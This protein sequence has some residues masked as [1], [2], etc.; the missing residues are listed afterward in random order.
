M[1]LQAELD[2]FNEEGTRNLEPGDEWKKSLKSDVRPPKPLVARF[3]LK[4]D[5]I[6]SYF[7]SISLLESHYNKE[8][9][10][11]DMVT[12]NLCNGDTFEVISTLEKFEKLLD[13]FFKEKETSSVRSTETATSKKKIKEEA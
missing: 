6:D 9:A 2:N 10:I 3:R 11:F 7:E 4:P 12:V 1:Y 8:N 13:D 5:L